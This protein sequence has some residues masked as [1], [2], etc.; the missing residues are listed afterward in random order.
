MKKIISIFLLLATVATVSAQRFEWA[1]GYNSAQEDLNE[2]TGSVV[3]SLGSTFNAGMYV[4]S[5]VVD[6]QIMDT[7]RMILTK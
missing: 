1:K 5:L 4:Y 7:K 3:D 2:I 6:N